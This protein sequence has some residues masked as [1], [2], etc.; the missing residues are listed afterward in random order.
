M[1][2]LYQVWQKVQ[3][4]CGVPDSV[5]MTVKVAPGYVPEIYCTSSVCPGQSNYYHTD[6]ICDNYEW[7]VYGAQFSWSG[8]GTHYIEV[9]WGTGPRR[10][11]KPLH[12]GLWH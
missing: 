11:Y 12:I 8:Q 6:P 3:N 5:S 7:T 10:Q 2:A 9:D 4:A 1:P